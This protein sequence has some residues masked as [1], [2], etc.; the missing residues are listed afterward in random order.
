MQNT[1]IFI[2]SIGYG[3]TERFFFDLVN[4]LPRDQIAVVYNQDN[5]RIR[6]FCASHN[7]RCHG[8][9]IVSARGVVEKAAG[10]NSWLRTVVVDLIRASGL[11]VLKRYVPLFLSKPPYWS[12]LK[13]MSAKFP[14]L[15]VI[16]GGYPGS[17]GSW[18]AAVEAIRL[19]F[20]KSLMTVLSCPISRGWNPVT[21]ILGW[22]V[23]HYIDRRIGKHVSQITVNATE[24]REILQKR[25]G[26]ANVP[27][28]VIYTGIEPQR[29]ALRLERAEFNGTLIERKSGE[30]LLGSI[31]Y[32]TR[33]KGHRYLLRAASK[34]S[35][36][37]VP[38]KLILAGDG[39]DLEL[40]KSYAKRSGLEDKV[41]LL[42]YCQD[43]DPLLRLIDV[44]VFPSLHE[45]LPY[46]VSEAMSYGLPVIA[47]SV[48]GIPEQVIDGETGYLCPPADADN[49]AER[50]REAVSDPSKTSALGVKAR[51]RAEG[52]FSTSAMLSSFKERL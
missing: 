49:L 14:T 25:V 47:T 3:G 31:S 39:P 35:E 51:K 15:L 48:G 38:F 13:E 6:D 27:I 41:T 19:G 43:V 44:F 24:I 29:D 11:Y 4:G 17:D 16:N 52:V 45:G 33:G 5:A 50:I 28:D 7:I 1:L 8:V 12:L 40:L 37:G 30:V 22:P 34:L 2:D 20:K 9:A 10:T 32:M 36:E 46:V 21:W 23:D 26:L 18:Q 42:G